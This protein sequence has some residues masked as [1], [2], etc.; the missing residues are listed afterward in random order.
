MRPRLV[1][2]VLFVLALAATTAIAGCG[3]SGGGAK[4][5]AT[6]T[7]TAAQVTPEAARPAG[8]PA[9]RKVGDFDH[10]TYVAGAPGYPDL[11]FVVE[12]RGR[13]EMLNHGKRVGRPF[14]DLRSRVDY[15]GAER[16]LLSIAF[17][18]DYRASGR[19]YVYYVDKGGSIEIDEFHRASPTRAA[20]GSRRT[21]ITVPHP[22]N[23]NH[24]G[25]QMQF[26]GEDL[27]FATG[28]GGAAGDPPNN[29]QDKDVLLG[30]LL[31]IDPLPAE[32][33]PY[34][35]PGSNPFVG[36][37]GRAE[38]YSYGLRNPFRFSFD[39]VTNP[40]EPRIVIGDVGQNRFEEI[41][42]TTLAGARGAN[43]GWDAREGY[44]R[45]EEEDSGT[46]DPG[47]TTKPIFAYPHSRG[48]SCSV[49]GGYVVADHSL[50]LLYGHYIYAD[51]CEG[52]LRALTLHLRRASGDHKLG[53]AVPSPTSFGEDDA[54]HVYVTSQEG[55]VYRLVQR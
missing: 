3:G 13:V 23:A 26:L 9:L 38:I 15:D 4:R 25:G 7:E 17:P 20:P 5:T 27:Y 11:L 32:G 24:N 47:G 29:A 1:L 2:A 31:R 22:V 19:F 45:Y 43:F 33:R 28:D 48:G 42:Y 36:G 16:G 40:R 44:A 34:T 55:P 12:Q 39:S 50:P 14:L 49:I 46:P 10:P 6:A 18:P 51:Y 54:H 41:D 53:L 21:V 52:R 35:V 37:P 30:K 8:K